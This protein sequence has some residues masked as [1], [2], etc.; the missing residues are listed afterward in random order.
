MP[1]VQGGRV[2][3]QRSPWRL[4]LFSDIF[5]STVNLIHAFFSTLLSPQAEED[6]IQKRRGGSRT[7]HQSGPWGPG[8]GGGGGRPGGGPPGPRI[9]GMAN[10]RTVS[11]ARP[12]GG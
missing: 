5:W 6:Y 8:G 2:L 11:Q 9:S 10:L 4:S 12:A 3:D 1:Y 7:S